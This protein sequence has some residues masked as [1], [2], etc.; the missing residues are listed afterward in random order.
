MTISPDKIFKAHALP[1][2]FQSRISKIADISGCSY[3]EALAEVV[4]K[5]LEEIDRKIDEFSESK[6]YNEL[7]RRQR[8][9]LN[10][11]RGGMAVKEL[12][13]KLGISEATVRTH[14]FRLRQRLGCNDLLKL[15]IPGT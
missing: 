8:E 10:G 4:A 13:H 3:D 11:L 1:K 5:G 9:V 15:R 12:A 14:I 7:S 6:E 2:P